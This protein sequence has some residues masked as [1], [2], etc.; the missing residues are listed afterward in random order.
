MLSKCL[1]GWGP[2]VPQEQPGTVA[3]HGALLLV[4]FG[5]DPTSDT[6]TQPTITSLT[7]LSCWGLQ[8][9]KVANPA[10]SLESPS[11]RWN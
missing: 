6:R 2:A 4:P 10:P 5:G 7:S 1:D 11:P 3:C 8:V 9:W